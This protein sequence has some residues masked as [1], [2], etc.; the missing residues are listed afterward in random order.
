M[1]QTANRPN[2]ETKP[3]TAKE[4]LS[5]WLNHRA[6][7]DRDPIGEKG[8]PTYRHFWNSWISYLENQHLKWHDVAP[9]DVLGFVRS[10]PNSR[11][12]DGA[13][14]SDITKRRY[15]RL[16]E[17]I[18]GFAQSHGWVK[19]NP[20]QRIVH[21][22][23]PPIEDPRGA[24][25]LPQ[26]WNAA[27]GL[28]KTRPADGLL[29]ARNQALL[30][31]LFELGLTPQEVRGLTMEALVCKGTDA[32]ELY[33]LQIHG[34]GPNQQRLIILPEHV[35]ESLLAWIARRSLMM[36]KKAA[37]NA[38]FCTLRRGPMSPDNLFVLVRELITQA[39]MASGQPLPPRLGPQIVRNTRLV[40]WLNQ[41]VPASQVAVWAGLKNIKG[42]YHLREHMNPEV[43]LTVRNVRDDER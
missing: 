10:G 11:K 37:S 41:G 24:I 12:N 29:D 21:R 25:L 19:E 23:R 8:E 31:V 42:L 40:A 3:P 33:A 43:R 13:S 27:L 36:Q 35:R 18:Y 2:H 32:A 15:W 26:L 4:I 17:R 22:E 5:I 39:A 9:E 14:E 6:L 7:S 1:Y 28:V 38:L 34:S 30:L 20:A 16:L